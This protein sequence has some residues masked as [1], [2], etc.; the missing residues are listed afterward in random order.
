[1][2]RTNSDDDRELAKSVRAYK[3]VLANIIDLNDVKAGVQ[4]WSFGVTLG[5]MLVSYLESPDTKDVLDA[6]SGSN[7]ILVK[8][9]VDGY[10][11]YSNS[12]FERT[13]TP[14]S[15]IYS[16]WE[17]DCKDLTS[18][19]KRKSYEELTAVVKETR[20]A[21]LN[22]PLSSSGNKGNLTPRPGAGDNV[23]EVELSDLEAKLNN[24]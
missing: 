7:F 24:L 9:I 12:R 23:T 2:Y 21:L 15:Q 14:L 13:V 20:E 1:L 10:P 17:S 6:T 16:A 11:K 22:A 3:Q 5:K 8:D 18:F 19:I 4:V